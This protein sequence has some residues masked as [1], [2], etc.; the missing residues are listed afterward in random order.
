MIW[1]PFFSIFAILSFFLFHF[2]AQTASQGISSHSIPVLFEIKITQTQKR[3]L[4]LK[5]SPTGLISSKRSKQQVYLIKKVY[6]LK[7]NE[8]CG[9]FKLVWR[10]YCGEIIF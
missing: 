1:G 3:N 2:F 9:S 4:L 7:C 6:I 8:K 10:I 5:R